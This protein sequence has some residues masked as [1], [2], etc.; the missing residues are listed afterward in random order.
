MMNYKYDNS[1]IENPYI[2]KN[3]AQLISNSMNVDH[4]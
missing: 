2:K 3:S 1:Y 4:Y